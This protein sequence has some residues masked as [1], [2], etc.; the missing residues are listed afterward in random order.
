M[1]DCWL[2]LLMMMIVSLLFFADGC[3][4]LRP[5]IVVADVAAFVC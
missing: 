4:S 1:V 3:Q 5:V 2:L